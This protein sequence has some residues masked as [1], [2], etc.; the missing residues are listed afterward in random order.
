[1]TY[2]LVAQDNSFNPKYIKSYNSISEAKA[3][4]RNDCN[5]DYDEGY[6]QA[7][8]YKLI[9][10]KNKS[11]AVSNYYDARNFMRKA[12]KNKAGAPV[13]TN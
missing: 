8:S 7:H 6:T 10:A 3:N 5:R 13:K 12:G 4:F 1:M 9:R 2:F 11:N